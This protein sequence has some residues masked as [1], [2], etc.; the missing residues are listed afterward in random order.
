MSYF[1]KFCPQPT[2]L[3][4]VFLCGFSGTFPPQE[5]CIP[6]CH[7]ELVLVSIFL[8]TLITIFVSVHHHGRG[9]DAAGHRDH[10]PA[11]EDG[12][13]PDPESGRGALAAAAPALLS[14]EVS[15]YQ[16][17]CHD[18]NVQNSCISMMLQQIKERSILSSTGK[19]VIMS[20]L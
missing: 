18:H 14:R 9:D 15:D 2:I 10:V 20:S 3:H 5:H 1:D 13:L 17:S 11:A 12:V 7:L 16:F 6:N 19:S 8:L 4:S